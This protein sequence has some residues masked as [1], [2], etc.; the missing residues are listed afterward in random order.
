MNLHSNHSASAKHAETN[1][2]V[3]LKSIHFN[4]TRIINLNWTINPLSNK[5]HLFIKMKQHTV[6]L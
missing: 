1:G 3:W 4:T 2:Y 5:K 6:N